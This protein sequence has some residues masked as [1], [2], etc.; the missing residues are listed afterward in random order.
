MVA[1]AVRR[2]GGKKEIQVDIRI[3]AATNKDLQ[4]ALADGELRE[5]LYYRLAVV[6]IDLP[7][8]RERSQDVQLPGE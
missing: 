5:D 2:L 7:P 8:L 4:K 3:V 1:C 6:Q